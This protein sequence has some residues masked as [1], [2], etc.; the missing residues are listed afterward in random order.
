V[1]CLEL[2]DLPHEVGRANTQTELFSFFY[3]KP[4]YDLIVIDIREPGWADGTEYLRK[5][6]THAVLGQIPVVV[7]A[8]RKSQSDIDEVYAIGAHLYAIKPYFQPNYV[9]MVRRIFQVDWNATPAPVRP[10]REDFVIN[11]AFA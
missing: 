11:H 8:E 7:F 1:L 10:E 6:K 9:Q 3:H 5:L 4:K 2:L